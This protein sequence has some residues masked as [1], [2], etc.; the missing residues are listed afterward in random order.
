MLELAE[1]VRRFE[2][3]YRGAVAFR[4]TTVQARAL[5]AI[6]T[7]RTPVRGGH[8]W[9]CD[10]AACGQ[11]RYS[12]HSCRHRLC[13]KCQRDQTERWLARAQTRL[14]PCPYW[15]ITVTLPAELRRI[16]R[17]HPKAV[18]DLL[19]RAAQ[20]AVIELGWTHLGGRV[21]LLAVLHTW[22]RALLF[23]P[24]V[25]VLVTAGGLDRDG[26][27]WRPARRADYL[28]PQQAVANRVHK[29]MREG[30]ERLGYLGEVPWEVWARKWIA[31]VQPAGAGAQVLAYLGRYVFR[32]P[33]PNSRITAITERTVTF[34]YRHGRT[35]HAQP[36]TLPGEHLVA[37]I[38]QHVLPHRFIR[39]RWS[40]LLSP[41]A[42]KARARA[43]AALAA[44]PRR[45]G[46]APRL[47][48]PRE[49]E[50]PDP[51]ARGEAHPPPVDSQSRQRCPVCGVGT[52]RL[53]GRLPPRRG[54]P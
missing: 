25:H 17:V 21:G 11:E 24:H 29:A 39:V 14:L 28:L 40:G 53:I 32:G 44:A 8:V 6:R 51:P 18:L 43:V 30:L 31:H 27:T 26:Q 19:L 7:C 36:T 37:R 38:I 49:D 4:V 15:L 10:A 41:A 1:V 34:T 50:V 9:R 46:H 20:T 47:T 54:P 13:P 12:Y 35:G 52:L 48:P 45:S 2:A 33:L 42:G 22:T 23:H 3:T 5:G 16:C